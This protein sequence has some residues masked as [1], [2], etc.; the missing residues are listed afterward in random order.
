[1][2]YV[3]GEA[4]GD[5]LLS[6]FEIT[7]AVQDPQN[8]VPL[9][10]GRNTL[11]RLYAK[12]A[13]AVKPISN[14]KI[15][16]TANALSQALM[17]SPSAFSTTIPLTYD[18]ANLQSTVNIPLPVEWTRGTVDITVRLDPGNEIGETN[19][20][21]N[22]FT[23]RFVFREVPPLEIK[24]VPVRYENPNNN[25]VYPAPTTD[26]IGEWILRTYP[27]AKVNVSFHDEI[28]FTGNLSSYQGFLD[29]INKVTGLKSSENLDESVVYYGL[30]P[31]SNGSSTWFYGGIAGI[32]WIGSRAAVGLNLPGGAA[33]I[34]A[35]EIGHNFGLW[36]SPCGSVDPS[37]L[38]ANYPYA[39]GSIGQYGMNM[40]RDNSTQVVVSP[41]AKDIMSYCPSRW[42][43]D[44]VYKR[45]FAAQSEVRSGP[46]YLQ[47]G[48]EIAQQGLMVRAQITS[49]GAELLPAYILPGPTGAPAA[50]DYQVEVLGTDG[51]V[52]AQVPVSAYT[53]DANVAE[54][55]MGINALVP[56][57]DQPAAG[58]RLLK[59]GQ[60]LAEQ[61]L[62]GGGAFAPEMNGSSESQ[63]ALV[64]YSR[65]GGE[66]WTTLGIDVLGGELLN[67]AANP[68]PDVIY[69][70]IPAG[71][72]Q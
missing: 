69:Q 44:Y 5:L 54:Q 29:L 13:G 68:E 71:V 65:D 38:E 57:P 15:N 53:A 59:D 14:V 32:G 40:N 22:T 51:T 70:V 41:T 16:I 36:H 42:I 3:R 49:S 26:T 60:V 33:Q 21:N 47:N 7:Q 23:Q 61:T 34:A 58:F 62:Q 43:S 18:R 10:A 19:E 4:V 17:G 24:I 31:I 25:K 6:G 28:T 48:G 11:L 2:P 56:L 55:A 1:M 50:G 12:A 52:I 35:H 37:T 20:T 27:V 46:A 30:V 72:A 39:D 8:S 66:T 64:R 9:V 45:L 63:P 67:R